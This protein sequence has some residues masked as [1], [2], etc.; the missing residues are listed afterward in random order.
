M[1]TFFSIKSF[2]QN[3]YALI[4]AISEYKDPQWSKLSS[5]NDVMLIQ[6]MLGKQQFPSNQIY[7]LQESQATVNGLITAFD[8]LTNKLQKGDI[9]YFH[10]SGHGQLIQDAEYK[11]ISGLSL[12]KDEEDGY[13]ESLVLYDGP[14]KWTNG[15]LYDGHFPDDL[16]KNYFN[17]IRKKIGDKGQMVAIF[18]CCHSGTAT[19]GD[20]REVVRGS[21]VACAPPDY[22]AE[23]SAGNADAAFD[24]DLEYGIGQQI[25]KLT[26]FFGCRSEQ[27]AHEY[28]NYGSLTYFLVKSMNEL[29][30][31]SSYNNLFSKINENMV[32][33]F[34][35]K[36]NPEI[37]GDDLNELIFKGTLVAQ[38]P[39]FKLSDIKGD[40]LTIDGGEMQG[41]QKGDSIGFYSNTT[42]S[43]KTGSLLFSGIVTE[44]TPFSSDVKLTTSRY[45]KQTDTVVYRAFLRYSASTMNPTKV[46]L[47]ISSKS[48]R[49]SVEK[50]LSQEKNIELV[51]TGGNYLIADTVT[52]DKQTGLMIYVGNDR[53]YALREMGPLKAEKNPAALDSVTLLLREA[54]RADILRGLHLHEPDLDF[55]YQVYGC[56]GGTSSFCKADTTQPA[57]DKLKVKAGSHFHLMLKSNTT[58]DLYINIIDI[59]PNGQ[60]EWLTG[61]RNSNIQLKE[62][63]PIEYLKID[64]TPP[65]GMEQIKLVA[66]DSPV[67]F[68]SIG[69]IGGSLA[70]TRGNGNS[71][72]LNEFLNQ[73]ENGTRGISGSASIGITTKTFTF[74]IIK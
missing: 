68:A 8:N 34:T 58:R 38:D 41:L 10:F 63:R 55:S 52:G 26:S 69:R 17:N 56:S 71:S 16:I 24:S 59:M 57:G 2:A 47:E 36:Q 39:F 70:A 28:K 46:K 31:K 64:I 6:E 5:G 19:R 20:G 13:D 74:E 32:I 53:T 4:V 45:L 48:M 43:L 35:N 67:S 40:V 1:A 22:K 7:L 11:H 66:G 18:D 37:E 30:E 25:G 60:M 65:Y 62:N 49:K 3:K 54:M 51:T 29:G 27:V 14:L 44:T 72:V 12:K 61:K 50:L 73:P 15:Y 33:A 23:K 21:S 9:V 42:T